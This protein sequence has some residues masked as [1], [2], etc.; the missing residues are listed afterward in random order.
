MLSQNHSRIV[1][2]RLCLFVALTW[3]T[4]NV[5]ATAADDSAKEQ[6]RVEESGNVVKD[7]LSSS[8]GIPINLLNKS[9]CGIVV[10][11]C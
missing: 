7:L 9:E 5:P 6:Q 11:S 2:L 1:A 8:N 10:N 3:L 4:V